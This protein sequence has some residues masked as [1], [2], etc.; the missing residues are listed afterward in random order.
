M[1]SLRWLWSAGLLC[2][3]WWVGAGLI[4]PPVALA[5]DPAVTTGRWAT[6]DNNTPN[7]PGTAPVVAM[8]MDGSDHLWVGTDG[9]GIAMFDGFT[10]TPYTNSNTSGKLLSDNV[11]F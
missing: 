5:A 7:Y 8:V 9:G 6:F 4:A 1:R 10:W 2:V 11:T 3:L